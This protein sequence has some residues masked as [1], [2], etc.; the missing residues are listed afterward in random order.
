MS[1]HAHTLAAHHVTEESLKKSFY[2]SVAFHVL[3][4]GG[5]LVYVLWNSNP[6]AF[7]DPNAGGTVVGVQAVDRIPLV[8]RGQQNPVANDTKSNVPQTPPPPKPETKPKA[9]PEPKE[10]VPLKLEQK[11]TQAEVDASRSQ[12]RPYEELAQNQLTL[13]SPQALADPLF[14]LSGSGDRIGETDSTLGTRFA[15]YGAE[16][17][18]RVA[19]AWRTQDVPANIKTAPVVIATFDIQR[20]GQVTNVHLL[21]KSG[22]PTLDLSVERAILA[23]APFSRLPAAFEKDTATVEFQFELKR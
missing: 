16:V 4:V 14:A 3:L 11:R 23:A 8:T 22:I 19:R 5:A 21:Q 13:P 20:D 2:A 9:E 15:A 10:A 7:G 6:D 18:K 17:K 12:F 1:A